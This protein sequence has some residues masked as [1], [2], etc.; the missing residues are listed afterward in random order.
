MASAGGFWRALLGA[1][2]FVGFICL[3]LVEIRGNGGT[4][5]TILI[6]TPARSTVVHRD[7]DLTYM[8]KR[9]VPNGP[10]PI[11]NRRTGNSK[12]PPGRA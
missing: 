11:H 5:T 8:S 4:K 9:R 10:D 3:L 2:V 12:R 1:L 6:A 7:L